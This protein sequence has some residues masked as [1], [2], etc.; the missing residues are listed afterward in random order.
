MRGDYEKAKARIIE[1]E[2]G[3][4]QRRY[5]CDE[6]E[7]DRSELL[8]LLHKTQAERVAELEAALGEIMGQGLDVSPAANDAEAHYYAVACNSIRIASRALG[9]K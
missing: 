7:A 4:E 3:L 8:K 6:L 9:A 1:L 2:A 5:K